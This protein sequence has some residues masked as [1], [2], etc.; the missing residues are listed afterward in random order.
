VTPPVADEEPTQEW[1]GLGLV[2]RPRKPSARVGRS[3]VVQAH[4]ADVARLRRSPSNWFVNNAATSRFPRNRR[5]SSGSSCRRRSRSPRDR[6]EALVERDL[7]SQPP[8]P[9][10]VDDAHAASAD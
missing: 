2:R 7:P 4:Q 5:R 9:G 6:G 1:V 10:E 3:V 8:V